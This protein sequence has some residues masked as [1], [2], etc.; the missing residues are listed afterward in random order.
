M[1]SV[2]D[3]IFS[4]WFVEEVVTAAAAAPAAEAADIISTPHPLQTLTARPAATAFLFRPFPLLLVSTS[5][6]AIRP[7]WEP[8]DNIFFFFLL[9]LLLLFLMEDV[10]LLL[11]LLFFLGMILVVVVL[12]S[13]DDDD[14]DDDGDDHLAA[15]VVVD[16][17]LRRNPSK[18]HGT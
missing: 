10:L 7:A 18:Q 1:A 14:D 3:N 12:S 11:L 13:P 6:D 2:P 16:P 9:L 4:V 8:T 5:I 15:L 17:K